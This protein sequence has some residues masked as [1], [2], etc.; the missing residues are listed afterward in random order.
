[1]NRLWV[2][3][4][5]AFLVVTWAVLGV[6]ALVVYSSVQSSFRQY[7]NER[8]A[9]LF[10]QPLIDDL[11]NYYATT[12]SWAGVDTVLGQPGHGRSAGGRGPQTYV[13]EPD[14]AI[15]AATDTTWVGQSFE[16]IGPSRTTSLL[17]D[18]RRIGILGQQTPGFQALD[19]AEHNFT[20]Q[21]NQGLLYAGIATT[22]LALGL[23]IL[24]SFN[25][26]QP[27]RQLAG[28]LALWTPATVG[29]RVPVENPAPRCCQLAEEFQRHVATPGCSFEQVRQQ[30]GG[31]RRPR[32]AHA[33]PSCAGAGHARRRLSARCRARMHQPGRATPPPC[34]LRS[35]IFALAHPR[36]RQTGCRSSWRPLAPGNL[37]ARR[38]SPASSRWQVARIACAASHRRPPLHRR[39]TA[40][41]LQVFDN[42]L[43]NALHATPQPGRNCLDRSSTAAACASSSASSTPRP[44][45]RFGRCWRRRR[46]RARR[47]Q[48]QAGAWPS[49]RQIVLLHGGA[50]R[51]EP[52]DGETRFVIDL[53]ARG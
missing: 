20:A 26:T 34:R 13:A 19:E 31:R 41:L 7:V 22:L 36:P 8:D 3:L 1:M 9:A 29:E 10:G 43:T 32:V 16:A 28:R 44:P 39:T 21:V 30:I 51:V 23:G 53:P 40:R 35:T 4:A 27:L 49:P 50:I 47:R 48:Q 52:A 12:G 14:G 37:V 15:V 5:L 42:L 25:L 6:V 11:V 33:S 38:A 45:H 2:R 24:L 18:G 46:P 17:L